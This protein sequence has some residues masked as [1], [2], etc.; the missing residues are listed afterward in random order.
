MD[1]ERPHLWRSAALLG[2]LATL[3]LAAGLAALALRSPPPRTYREL[4]AYGLEQR[5]VAYA[6][7]EMGEMW[8]D[9]TNL[10][11]QIYARPVSIAV[12]VRLEDGSLASG[13]LQCQELE[14]GCTLSIKQLGIEDAPLPDLAAPEP[15]PWLRWLR[16]HMPG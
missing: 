1:D 2:G 13:W 4:V 8:P 12:R 16:E 6:R 5:G 9:R 11:Y 10:Q 3:C 14:R 15:P 7:I